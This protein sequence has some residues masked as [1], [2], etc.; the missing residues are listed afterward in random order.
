MPEKYHTVLFSWFCLHLIRVHA[1][2]SAPT[3]G[4]LNHENVKYL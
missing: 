4:R 3:Y 2:Y 1:M